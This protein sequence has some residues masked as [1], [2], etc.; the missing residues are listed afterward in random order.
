M[1]NLPRM[2]LTKFTDY[3]LRVM[4]HLATVAPAKRSASAIS[5]V[6]G[7]SENHLAKVCTALARANLIV[8]ERGRSGGLSLAR[9]AAEISLGDVVR[10]LSADLALVECFSGKSDCILLSVCGMCGPLSD[11]REA[12]YASLDKIS[13]E[14]VTENRQVL[15]TV[16]I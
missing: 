9:P 1:L 7:I 3:G 13:F 12:F 4:I 15:Q 14:A 16:L 5:A 11:A 10:A 8:S 6:F 2:Q